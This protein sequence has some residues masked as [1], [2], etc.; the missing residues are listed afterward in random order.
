[1]D[2][3]QIVGIAGAL[4]TAA[5]ILHAVARHIG[6]TATLAW[7][8]AM[9][10]VPFAG[11]IAYFLLAGPRLRRTRR[12]RRLAGEAVR[13]A[14]RRRLGPAGFPAA[15]LASS[16]LAQS[17]AALGTRLTGL[18][19]SAGNLV[20]LRTDNVRTFE[21]M[22]QAVLAAERSVWAEYYIVSDDATGRAFLALLAEKAR[23]GVDVRLLY[24]AVGS[25]DVPEDGLEAL[26]DSGG[27][28]EAFLPVNP[29]RRRWAVHLRNHR[30]L[31]VVDGERA[32]LGGMNVG[33]AYAGGSAAGST[34]AE[35]PWRDTNLALSG[36]AVADLATVFAED[37]TFASDERLVPPSVSVPAR[38]GSVVGIV[39]SGPDQAANAAEQTYFAAVTGARSRCW[40]T[41]PYFVPDEGTLRALASAAF[42]GVDLRVLVPAHG[43][44]AVAQAAGRWYYRALLRA[45][46]RVFEYEPAVLHAKTL[47]V[48]GAFSL[49][50]S[51]NL[52]FRSF[53]LNFEIGAV[54]FDPEFAAEM[55]GLFE[56]DLAE[57]REVTRAEVEQRSLPDRLR[58]GGARLLAPL[59]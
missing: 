32:F 54:V 48:D 43:D 29:F 4:L 20:A 59:L 22:K 52:D 26:R 8:F 27:R 11:P 51:A 2:L 14:M 56:A 39:P 36:P 1:M 7:I 42:R 5:G 49:V 16:P 45:G 23:Q 9:L 28:A 46:A 41:T 53:G 10:A 34:P 24:D 6:V 30:K 31:L 35:R 19:P 44:V 37:W 50:G 17:V 12:H 38:G 18:P 25:S 57:S 15:V 55:E 3:L 13:K 21:E 47:V 33:D 40:L 58:L